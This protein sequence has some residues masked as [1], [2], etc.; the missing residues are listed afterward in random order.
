MG[1]LGRE[2]WKGK[3]GKWKALEALRE[4]SAGFDVEECAVVRSGSRRSSVS[5]VRENQRGVSKAPAR[6]TTL[7]WR[8]SKGRRGGS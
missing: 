1:K 2:S 5:A 7:R 4:L 8:Q 3:V 6:M